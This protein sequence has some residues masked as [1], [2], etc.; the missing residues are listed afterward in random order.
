MQALLERY[1]GRPLPRRLSLFL[2]NLPA[3]AAA[4]RRLDGQA[5]Y[6][7]CWPGTELP[8]SNEFAAV[9]TKLLGDT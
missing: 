7:R 3:A 2:G 9:V 8:G 5:D 4:R 6:N 1:R